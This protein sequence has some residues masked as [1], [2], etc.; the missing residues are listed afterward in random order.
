M[1]RAHRMHVHPGAG[2]FPHNRARRRRVIEVDVREQ[3]R[4]HA[5]QRVSHFGQ[6]GAQRPQPSLRPGIDQRHPVVQLQ[7]PDPD[8]A[9]EPL[10]VQVDDAGAA[11]D[12]G[13]RHGL[14][15]GPRCVPHFSN[16]LRR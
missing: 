3:D 8:D 6:A 9:G 12:A 15:I 10:V 7:H 16:H 14:V 13:D 5:L 4:A 1:G 2:R 11:S